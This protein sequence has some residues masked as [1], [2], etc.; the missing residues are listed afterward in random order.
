MNSFV[1][2]VTLAFTVVTT[3]GV[4]AHDTQL[5]R[6]SAIAITAP[7]ALA[8]YVVADAI[9]SSEHLHVEKI[10]MNSQ[11]GSFRINVPR[12]QARN[13]DR[14]YVQVKRSVYGG[15]DSHGLWPSI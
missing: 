12:T 11:V 10:S 2:S 7:A 1:K 13:D 14:K 3:F 6:M 15:T 4:L 5:D 9:K 8:M